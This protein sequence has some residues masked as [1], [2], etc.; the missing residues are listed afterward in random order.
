M[1]LFICSTSLGWERA[2]CFCSTHSR[3]RA[4]VVSGPAGVIWSCQKRACSLSRGRFV[5]VSLR[6]K[7]VSAAQ[8][9]SE[10]L[11]AGPQAATPLPLPLVGSVSERPH[12]PLACLWRGWSKVQRPRRKRPLFGFVQPAFL[13]Q[14]HTWLRALFPPASRLR[15][16]LAW[17][18]LWKS[19]LGAA[20]SGRLLR[21]S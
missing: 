3:P 15:W 11:I 6:I 18:D 20:G 17:E 14:S 5:Y 16:L 10:T 4:C 19:D 2:A 12:P 8:H 21:G 13:H 9:V 7:Y 1:Y